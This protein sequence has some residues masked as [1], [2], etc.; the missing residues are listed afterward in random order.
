MHSRKL[1]VFICAFFIIFAI[2]GSIATAEYF[3]VTVKVLDL[4]STPYEN[5]MIDIYQGQKIQLL[6]TERGGGCC[7][8]TD[9]NGTTIL[10]IQGEVG[11][12]Y[13]VASS[14]RTG[15]IQVQPVYLSGENPKVTI[16]FNELNRTSGF[17][18]LYNMT[19]ESLDIAEDSLGMSKASLDVAV[20]S[21]AI[22]VIGSIVSVISIII[23]RSLGKKKK[24]EDEEKKNENSP[25]AKDP[26][27]DSENEFLNK[28]KKELIT[29]YNNAFLDIRHVHDMIWKI[30]TI[31]G[32]AIITLIGIMIT[33]NNPVSPS[34][35]FGDKQIVLFVLAFISSFVCFIS[36][37]LLW[38]YRKGFLEKVIMVY[39]IEKMWGFHDDKKFEK[40]FK[41]GFLP[42]W[43]EH[44][45]R[46][47]DE[48]KKKWWK[49]SEFTI[50]FIFF[51]VL[52]ILPW[53]V[54][55]WI[56]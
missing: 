1:F 56:W 37:F 12:Y 44:K 33:H 50:F 10:R 9:E 8:V 24:P 36:L 46:Y 52:A 45:D 47:E 5:V 14:Y 25:P 17:I 38:R 13:I 11:Y 6:G 4:N 51:C 34:Q 39:R 29:L 19:K 55:W 26:N 42:K 35:Q 28:R 48:I 18:V 49:F 53:F 20:L 27:N 21:L 15:A 32:A 3:D 16:V 31:F 54:I 30:S 23:A 2:G 22:A 41:E 7:G 40:W 43:W